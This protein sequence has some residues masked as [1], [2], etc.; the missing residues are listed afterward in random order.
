MKLLIDP[1]PHGEKKVEFSVINKNR[2]SHGKKKRRIGDS[3]KSFSHMKR[4]QNIASK[5]DHAI[6]NPK[7]KPLLIA[8]PTIANAGIKKTNNS[9]PVGRT[10]Q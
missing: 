4:N 2:I 8:G 3:L 5:H 9:V 6:V 10:N 1:D 7:P